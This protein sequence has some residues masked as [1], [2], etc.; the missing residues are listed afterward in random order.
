MLRRGREY[1]RQNFVRFD[2]GS[3]SSFRGGQHDRPRHG[4][5]HDVPWHRNRTSH[6]CDLILRSSYRIRLFVCQR[7][8]ISVRFVS[9]VLCVGQREQRGLPLAALLLLV[10]ALLPALRLHREEVVVR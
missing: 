3:S 4:A 8:C 9:S 7:I 2:G 5:Q 6:L 1:W 10:R